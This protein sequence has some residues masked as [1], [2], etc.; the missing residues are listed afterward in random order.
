MAKLYM[1]AVGIVLILVG[2]V[3]FILPFPGLL[4]LT[5][6]HNVVHLATGA[7]AL[8]IANTKRNMITLIRLFGALYL[9]VGIVGL[10]IPNFLGLIPLDPADTV[11]HFV[12]AIAS[13]AVGFAVPSEEAIRAT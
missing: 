9:V 4:D 2:I 8:A 7:A 10:F 13:L 11:I 12:L 6:A 1:T 5:P 3:G